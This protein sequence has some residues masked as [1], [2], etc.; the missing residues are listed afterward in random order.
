MR[1]YDEFIEMIDMRELGIEVIRDQV[2][3]PQ[4]DPKTMLKLIVY[5]YGWRSSRKIERA[6]YHNL[7]Q[8]AQ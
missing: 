5:A 6:L 1:V 2:G 7:T 4:Y 3:N 8:K